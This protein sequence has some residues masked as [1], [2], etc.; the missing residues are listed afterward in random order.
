MLRMTLAAMLAALSLAAPATAHPEDDGAYMPR[1]PSTGELAQQAIA[2]LIEQKK[3]P[4]SWNSAKL[5]GFDYRSYKGADQYVLTFENAAIKQAAKRKLFVVMT[6]SGQ[7][8][9]TSHKL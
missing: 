1:G 6:T 5:T 9:S 2:K 8:V 4:A 7:L 3:L